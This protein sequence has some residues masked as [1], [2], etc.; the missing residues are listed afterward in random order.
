M[1]LLVVQVLQLEVQAVDL[2]P[3]LGGLGFCIPGVEV[4][5]AVQAAE[6]RDVCEEELLLL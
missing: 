5:G 6:V 3:R 2:L 4:G 1:A